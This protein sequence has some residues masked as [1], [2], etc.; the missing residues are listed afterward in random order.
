M[1]L[2]KS[3]LKRHALAH[4]R[5]RIEAGDFTKQDLARWREELGPV[6]DELA[7]SAPAP[8]APSSKKKSSTTTED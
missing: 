8:A 5:R 7:S 4:V 3:E 1:S 2:S 6:V